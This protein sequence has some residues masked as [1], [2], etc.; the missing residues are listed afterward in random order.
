MRT[1]AFAGLALAFALG[2]GLAGALNAPAADPGP[3]TPGGESS[4]TSRP[5]S[6]PHFHHIHLNVTDPDATIEFY[7]HFFGANR[8]TYRNRVDAVFA[9]RSFI[10]MDV[11]DQPPRDNAGTTLW[12]IGWAG[13]D[14]HSEFAW[15]ERA[16]IDVQTPLT[17]LGDNHFMYFWGPDRELVEVYTGSRNHRFEHVHLLATDIDS[18]LAWFD[19]HLDLRPRSPTRALSGTRMRLNTL[20]IDNINLII[21]EVPA[22][23]EERAWLLPENVGP[24]FAVTDGR[25][26]DHI[27][28]SYSD[29]RPVAE[30]MRAAGVEFVRDVAPDP[31]HGLTS[32]FIR[33]PDGLLVE[34]VEELPVPEGLWW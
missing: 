10:L 1:R 21:F 4:A 20:R 12:H 9:D 14:G 19:R 7:E 28:F 3:S 22:P 18:T 26:M 15:R 30:R 31:R 25:G 11:V 24:D 16:G 23:G 27:A 33:G 2:Y 29:I 34:I 8:V 32:F 5:A 13:V 17:P 6:G